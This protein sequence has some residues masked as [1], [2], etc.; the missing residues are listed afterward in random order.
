MLLSEIKI[1]KNLF[2]DKI[3]GVIHVGAHDGSCIDV[4]KKLGITSIYLF[5]P[6][7]D[8]IKKVKKKIFYYNL[9]N[10]NVVLKNFALSNYCGKSIFYV[11][12]N[13][14]ASSLLELHKHKDIYKNNIVIKKK[15]C[16]GQNP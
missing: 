2:K 14:Q 7:I 1:I 8:L 6:N 4:Y 12:S 10:M 13:D 11:N 15:N 9:F 5:E 3:K 16:K